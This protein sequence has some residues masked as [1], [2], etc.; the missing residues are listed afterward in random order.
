MGFMSAVKPE[1]MLGTSKKGI[2]PLPFLLSFK[3]QTQSG[4]RLQDFFFI[5]LRIF[6]SASG[7]TAKKVLGVCRSQ[8]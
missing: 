5:T 8:F 2:L 1:N 3:D 6:Y 7:F 4:F